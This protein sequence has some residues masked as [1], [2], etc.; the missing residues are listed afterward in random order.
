MPAYEKTFVYDSLYQIT[1][2][3]DGQLEETSEYKSYMI[4][5]QVR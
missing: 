2:I 5:Q 4:M 3:N 1:R